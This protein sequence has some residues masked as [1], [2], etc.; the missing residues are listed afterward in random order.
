VVKVDRGSLRPVLTAKRAIAGLVAA[1]VLGAVAVSAVG[2]TT[3]RVTIIGPEGGQRVY[4]VD[5]ETEAAAED[6]AWQRLR[7]SSTTTAVPITP[8]SC[9]VTVEG[10][11]FAA[12]V[13]A[14]AVVAKDTAQGA[15]PE[16]FW[17]RMYCEQSSRY[18][19]LLTGGD[20]HPMAG[21]DPQGNS[22]YRRLTVHDGDNVW[23]ERCELGDNDWRDG[24]TA[25]Y[26][27]GQH[28]LTYISYRLGE[29]YPL[30]NPNWQVVM[31]MKQTQPSENGGGTPVISLEARDGRWKLIQ[32]N[33]PGYSSDTHVL[34]STPAET[35][36]WTRFA[37][38][39]VYSQD[40]DRGSIRL[41]VD[42]N[43][44]GDARDPGEQ[45]PVFK[46]YTLKYETANSDYFDAG[47]SLP[48]HLRAGVYHQ[49][50]IDCDLVGTCSDGVD[51]VQVVR[52][53]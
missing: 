45:S 28:R 27:E 6:L 33:S 20:P 42:L 12:S 19:Y 25:F 41:S 21:G 46:T 36:V 15:N 1:L 14:C 47:D 16:P 29:D 49:E 37:F 26:R 53:E 17:G 31:Q 2:H 52:A 44:D 23:G 40:P 24:P 51:N 50:Y 34:W 11:P 3:W 48:S 43:G 10:D 13:P 5:A 22:A 39:V 8:S 7:A 4:E 30:S 35:G 32:S 38:D 9:L 18:A